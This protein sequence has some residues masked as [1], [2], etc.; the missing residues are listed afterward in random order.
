VLSNC[1]TNQ[2]EY[3]MPRFSLRTLIVVMMLG[4]PVLAG[5]V[6]IGRELNWATA[7]LALVSACAGGVFGGL[8][9]RAI[10]A[11]AD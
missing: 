3:P 9:A 6:W 5:L 8:T 4:G 1:L 10:L 11:E 7:C 2:G